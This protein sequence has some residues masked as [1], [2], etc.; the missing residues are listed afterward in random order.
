MSNYQ[1]WIEKKKVFD[2]SKVWKDEKLLIDSNVCLKEIFFY[3]LIF[4]FFFKTLQNESGQLAYLSSPIKYI[5]TFLYQ[6]FL[7]MFWLSWHYHISKGVILA[8]T[9]T[10]LFV[11]TSHET[12]KY[13]TVLTGGC[14]LGPVILTRN[15]KCQVVISKCKLFES[16]EAFTTCLTVPLN[17]VSLSICILME[18]RPFFK[19]MQTE[20]VHSGG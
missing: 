10:Y 8:F 12:A 6:N 2:F 4:Y 16:L 9:F 17:L 1:F 20:A 11:T 13:E 7:I 14:Y 15:H 18:N 19:R 3:S 5:L